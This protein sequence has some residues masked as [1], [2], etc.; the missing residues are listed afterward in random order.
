MSARGLVVGALAL[1]CALV[2]AP[3]A[4]AFGLSG[5]GVRLGYLDPEASDGGVLLGGHLEFEKPDSYWHI[6]PN[7]LYWN[8]DPL[9]GW[10]LNL[11]ALYHFGPQSKTVPYLG[12]GLGASIVSVDGASG[13]NHTDLGV[14]LF[15]GAQIPA[16]GNHLFIEGRYTLSDVNQASIALGYTFHSH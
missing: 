14:N 7:L 6:R 8:A 13:D 4:H 11:D 12:A 3:S 2:V 5:G 15:G 1:A 10:N 9:N 16:G